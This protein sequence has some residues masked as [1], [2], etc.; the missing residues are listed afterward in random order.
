MLDKT[1]YLYTIK[2]NAVDE[3]FQSKLAELN[4]HQFFPTTTIEIY[5]T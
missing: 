1:I 2:D 3:L 5:K 4:Y